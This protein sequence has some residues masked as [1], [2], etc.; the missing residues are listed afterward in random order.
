ML[1]CY[2]KLTRR[3]ALLRR[4]S[5]LETKRRLP[6]R[7]EL[8]PSQSPPKASSDFNGQAGSVRFRKSFRHVEDL[9]RTVS[10]QM[11]SRASTCC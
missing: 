6:S 5:G 7:P 3:L 10:V 2:V 9:A 1:C 11:P 4:T 8:S